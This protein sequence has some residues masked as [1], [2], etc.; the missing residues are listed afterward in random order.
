MTH[1][2][3]ESQYGHG[4]YKVV[5]VAAVLIFMQ[6]VVLYGRCYSRHLKRVLLE[7]DDYVLMV[8]AVS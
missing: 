3:K 8:A 6:L 5:V 4:G 2:S 1:I 7:L